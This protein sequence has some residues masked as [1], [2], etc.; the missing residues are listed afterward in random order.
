MVNNLFPFHWT[1][2]SGNILM[3]LLRFNVNVKINRTFYTNVIAL[4]Y[5]TPSVI[6]L[7]HCTSLILSTTRLVK[8]R[9]C[10]GSKRHNQ[11]KFW[12]LNTAIICEHVHNLE[13]W[14]SFKF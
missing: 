4:C 13:L 5:C 2:H 8:I 7:F 1:Y 11:A 9:I 10:T 3:S 6:A 14:K 12:L